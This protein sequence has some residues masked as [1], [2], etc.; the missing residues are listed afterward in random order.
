MATATRNETPLGANVLLL[1]VGV[2]ALLFGGARPAQEA[3]IASE[4]PEST[5]AFIARTKP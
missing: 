5:G 2:I 4:A 1:A 3:T